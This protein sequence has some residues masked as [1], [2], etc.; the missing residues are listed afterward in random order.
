MDN[1]DIFQIWRVPA[2]IL[3]KKTQIEDKGWSY[4]LKV[5]RVG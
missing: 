5:G 4:N 3:V 1:E 2:N